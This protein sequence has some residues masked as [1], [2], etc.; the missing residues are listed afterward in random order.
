MDFAEAEMM[1]WQWHQQDHMQVTRTVAG[2]FCVLRRIRT[3]R[4]SVPDLV[5]QSLVVS[6]VLNRLDFGNATLAGLP[7]HQ[8]RRLQSV[9]NAARSSTTDLPASA[10]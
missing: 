5:F 6:L 2:G 10:F 7:A 3:I 9:L 4:R 1:G 8:Y